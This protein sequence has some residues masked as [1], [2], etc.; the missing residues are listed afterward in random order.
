MRRK[1]TFFWYRSDHAD[2][3]GKQR[4]AAAHMMRAATN[5]LELV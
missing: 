4:I 3:A 2:L 1:L 5:Q